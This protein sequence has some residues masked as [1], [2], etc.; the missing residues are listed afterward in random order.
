MISKLK[1]VIVI[2]LLILIILIVS[3]IIWRKTR[4]VKL[5][6]IIFLIIIIFIVIFIVLLITRIDWRIIIWLLWWKSCLLKL[7]LLFRRF[8]NIISFSNT[9]FLFQL[10]YEFEYNCECH[11]FVDVS[12]K[13][14]IQI[15]SNS[16][17]LLKYDR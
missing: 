7:S 2:S 13:T 17:K 3:L 9:L 14:K 5:I 12:L 11:E 16:I 15:I 10:M 4:I 6:A 1:I 8:F